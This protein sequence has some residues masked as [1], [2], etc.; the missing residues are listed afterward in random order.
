[1][2]L[3]RFAPGQ[4][5][6]EGGVELALLVQE[7]LDLGGLGVALLLALAHELALL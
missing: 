7:R 6:A 2:K 3:G 5:Q 4:G 1:M